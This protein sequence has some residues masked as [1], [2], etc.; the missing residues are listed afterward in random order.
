MNHSHI[1]TISFDAASYAI[2][3][4]LV[5]ML[6]P[7]SRTH[8]LSQDPMSIPQ[9]NAISSHA[10]GDS[11]CQKEIEPG[12]LSKKHLHL[13]EQAITRAQPKAFYCI[14]DTIN[15]HDLPTLKTDAHEPVC[16][17]IATL[18]RD[19]D[20]WREHLP[21]V[22]EQYV[23]MAIGMW[24][25]CRCIHSL[26]SAIGIY[27]GYRVH[28]PGSINGLSLKI[29]GVL[30]SLFYREAAKSG[31]VINSQFMF[32]PL[33]TVAGFVSADENNTGLCQNCRFGNCPFRNILT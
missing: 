18:G 28:Y 14:I 9:H 29:N 19:F 7:Q 15:D 24:L 11:G 30:Y 17:F 25:C 5:R 32:S 3:D 22:L 26:I 10:C 4:E 23:A 2:N 13:Y 27:N 33:Y 8:Q 1:V 20:Q 12:A 6:Q 31:I 16:G 21:T